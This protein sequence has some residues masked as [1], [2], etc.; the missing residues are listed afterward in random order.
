[1]RPILATVFVVILAVGSRAAEPAQPDWNGWSVKGPGKIASLEN[2]YI[3]IE[4]DSPE[5]RAVALRPAKPVALP[6]DLTRLGIWFACTRGDVNVRFLVTDAE[7]KEQVVSTYATKLQGPE[8]RH[9]GSRRYEWPRWTQAESKSLRFPDAAAIERRVVPE[10][11]DAVRE[12]IWPKPWTL[13]GVALIPAKTSERWGGAFTRPQRE[14]MRAGRGL[15]CLTG[16]SFFRQNSLEADFY[17]SI[18]ERL[19]WARNESQ[20]L[21]FDDLTTASG[22]IDW[23]IEIRAGYQGP[24]AWSREGKG[25]VDRKN[26]AGLFDERIVL[27]QL[28]EGDYWIRTR[29]WGRDGE[30]GEE[31]LFRWFVCEGGGELPRA[32]APFAW[33]TDREFNV[34]PPETRDAELSLEIGEETWGRATEEAACRVRVMDYMR[35]I[36]LEIDLPR[37]GQH[38]VNCPVAPGNDYFAEAEIRDGDSVFDRAYLHFGVANAPEDAGPLPAV[39]ASVPGR[40]EFLDGRACLQSEYRHNDIISRDYPW[41]CNFDPA[42]FETFVK[43]AKQIGSRTITVGSCLGDIAILPGVD[44]WRLLDEEVAIAGRHG[45]G[46]VFNYIMG[47]ADGRTCPL[48]APQTPFRDQFGN[49]FPEA[50]GPSHW[51]AEWDERRLAYHRRLARRFLGNPNVIGYQVKNYSLVEDNLPEMRTADYSRPAR[52]AFREWQ[53]TNGWDPLPLPAPFFLPTRNPYTPETGPDLS[54]EGVRFLDFNDYAGRRFTTGLIDAIRS[55]DSHRQIQV[56]RKHICYGVESLIPALRDGGALKNEGSPGFRDIFLHSMAEQAGVPFLEELHRQIPTSASIAD[57][58]YFYSSYLSRTAFWLLRWK[59]EHV[60]NKQHPMYRTLEDMLG[61]LE[62]VHP[63]WEEYLRAKEPEPRAL[64]F[65]SRA[66]QALDAPRRGE[67]NSVAGIDVLESLFVSHNLPAHFANEHADWVDLNHFSVVFARGEVMRQPAIER[68]LQYARGGGRL[69]L[70]GDAGRYCPERPAERD[71]LA[72]PLAGMENVRTLAEPEP[73]TDS[74]GATWAKVKAFPEAGLAKILAWAEVRRR[75]VASGEAGPGFQCILREAPDGE[76]VYA[77]VMR[78]WNGTFYRDEIEF[79]DDLAEKYGRQAGTA[80][81]HGLYPGRW[82]VEKFHR[83]S[84][85]L[86]ILAAPE[87]SLTIHLDP[88]FAGEVQLYRLTRVE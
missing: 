38:R 44:R 45:L 3:E 25:I 47:T 21:F 10:F 6:A 2:G 54:A 72:G 7:G 16:L 15:V 80:R 12:A 83:D 5:L 18:A 29:A 62:R 87:G 63:N 26:P 23:A 56:D 48:I 13:T 75:I 32:R 35:R 4:Y 84:R 8:I 60:E 11:R 14:D 22:P 69:V 79:Q 24:I 61:Y 88:A 57:A 71:L 33:S 1:M 42:D 53:Q 46:V 51:N 55:V 67:F 85:D 66:S 74:S 36:V 41:V 37:A 70:V 31:R 52:E 77:A 58:T 19:R 86:G 59:P 40:D 17:S 49:V 64:V 39:P 82:K 43:Q 28:P 65:G 34:F 9:E 73:V 27:P 50:P 78:T 81:V 30:L 68:I 20:V 76:R